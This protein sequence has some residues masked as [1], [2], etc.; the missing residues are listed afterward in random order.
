MR[1]SDNPVYMDSYIWLLSFLWEMHVL[2]RCCTMQRTIQRSRT[3]QRTVKMHTHSRS[4]ARF[5]TRSLDSAR[6]AL[7][8][9]RSGGSVDATRHNQRLP[10]YKL[11]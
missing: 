6:H 11:G 3:S 5:P 10:L 2:W 9:N 7:V 1:P 4:Y 8:Q